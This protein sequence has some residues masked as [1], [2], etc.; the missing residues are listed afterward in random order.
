MAPD[1]ST[2]AFVG[3]RNGDFDIYTSAV[4]G[5]DETP[6]T[7]AKGL[8][9]GPE[10]SPDGKYINS[11]RSGSMQIGRMHP[12]GN[13]REQITSDDFNNWFPHISPDGK[14]MVF[15]SYEKDVTGHPENKDVKLQLMS[16]EDNEDQRAGDLVWRT[17]HDQRPL[18]VARQQTTGIRKLSVDPVA[19]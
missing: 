1:G 11:E 13:G 2:L 8:G 15:L 10:Y 5:G 7:T 14:W 9:D 12:D 16:L 4:S 6:L 17:R 18:V 19:V 3:Q